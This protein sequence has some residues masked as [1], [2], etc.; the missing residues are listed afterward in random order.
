VD[1]IGGQT[2]R[3]PPLIAQITGCNTFPLK[4]RHFEAVAMAFNAKL[5]ASFSKLRPV[6][7]SH[8]EAKGELVRK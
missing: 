5:Q 4:I 1:Y 6:D 7:F 8:W 3:H 2:A